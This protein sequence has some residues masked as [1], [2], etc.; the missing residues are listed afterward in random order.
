MKYDCN[1]TTDYLHE[2]RRMCKAHPSCGACPISLTNLRCG[3]V[4]TLC[5]VSLV[6][7]VQKWSD[8]HPEQP[9]LTKRERE[10]LECF[11]HVDDKRVRKLN[12]C[13]YFGRHFGND[14]ALA[15]GMFDF[16]E[17]GTIMTGEEL[18]KLEVEE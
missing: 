8:E 11:K 16:V 6:D 9:K 10:F 14:M 7:I 3:T 12:G 17:N 13:A 18:L 2:V 4:P 15:N 1:K 5:D